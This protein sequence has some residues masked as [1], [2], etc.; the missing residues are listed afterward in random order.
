MAIKLSHMGKLATLEAKKTQ[1]V[2]KTR[3]ATQTAVIGNREMRVHPFTVWLDL[4]DHD[5][6]TLIHHLKVGLPFSSFERFSA[7]IGLEATKLA[8]TMA[9]PSSTFARVKKSGHLNAAQSEQ[10]VRLSRLFDLCLELFRGDQDK[11]RR[12][13]TTPKKALEGQTPLG[14]TTT[15]IGAREV[16]DLIG[17]IR[18]GVY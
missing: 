18:H 3:D 12:W 10:L 15:E 6:P 5:T 9:L 1:R 7:A 11:A 2:A 16:E 8:S 13:M 17:R 4:P 14:M